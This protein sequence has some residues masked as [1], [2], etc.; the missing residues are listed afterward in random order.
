M[1]SLTLLSAAFGCSAASLPKGA[2]EAHSSGVI[3]IEQRPNF[4]VF[5]EFQ[6]SPVLTERLRRA[7]TERGVSITEKEAAAAAVLRVGGSI[8]LSGGPRYQKTLQMSIG[9]AT[10]KSL[11]M[12]SPEEVREKELSGREVAGIVHDGAWVAIGYEIGVNKFVQGISISALVA[13]VGK[14]TGFSGWLNNKIFSDPRGICL[15][16]ACEDWNK[17]SQVVELKATYI[18]GGKESAVSVRSSAFDEVL[19][20]DE[21]LYE[22]VNSTLRSIRVG[23]AKE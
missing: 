3:E 22:A 5:A 2:V 16:A 19:A 21:V 4:T 1:I 6:D 20:P 13:S 12:Q 7:L 9:A 18:H 23:N 8:T 11:E 14:A 10:Q 15:G 17:V